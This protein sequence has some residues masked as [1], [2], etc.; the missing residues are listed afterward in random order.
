M[1]NYTTKIVRTTLRCYS[2][3]LTGVKATVW[4]PPKIDE[5]WQSWRSLQR[6]TRT[7]EI[8]GRF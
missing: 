1:R 3:R 7:L 8:W 4:T 6:K 2:S 5:L